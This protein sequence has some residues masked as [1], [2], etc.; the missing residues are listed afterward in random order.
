MILQIQLFMDR[1]FAYVAAF[2]VPY[3]QPLMQAMGTITGD[4]YTIFK[5]WWKLIGS[6]VSDNTRAVYNPFKIAPKILG[7]PQTKV[8]I[9]PHNRYTKVSPA[10]PADDDDTA[11]GI[12]Y[13]VNGPGNYK[14]VPRATKLRP[15]ALVL[16]QPNGRF[17]AASVSYKLLN[18]TTVHI[19]YDIILHDLSG[20][21]SIPQVSFLLPLLAKGNEVHEATQTV[22][23]LYEAIPKI[24]ENTH[25][26]MGRVTV[27]GP[28]LIF[29]TTDLEENIQYRVTGNI[30][31]R[32]Q[33]ELL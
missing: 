13:Y 15:W 22:Q 32:L 33:T 27:E 7:S 3:F 20:F 26:N 11:S 23:G 18:Q 14:L 17:N 1:V 24:V 31:Y 8:Y 12:M 21:K 16:V 30:T 29:S 19:A 2:F 25:Y 4:I 10:N 6:E 28:Y 9:P 5:G